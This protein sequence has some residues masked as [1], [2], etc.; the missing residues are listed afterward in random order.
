MRPEDGVNGLACSQEGEAVVHEE[1]PDRA[2]AERAPSGHETIVRKLRHR[3]GALLTALLSGGGCIAF[4]LALRGYRLRLSHVHLPHILDEWSEIAASVLLGAAVITV[5]I[6]LTL[7]LWCLW[8]AIRNVGDQDMANR[9][10]DLATRVVYM[11]TGGQLKGLRKGPAQLCGEVKALVSVA[12]EARTASFWELL[13][14][15]EQADLA[16]LAVETTFQAGSILCREG[17]RADHVIVI[18]SGRIKVCVE[19]PN[20]QQLVAIRHAGDIVGE[21]AA[22]QVTERSATITALETVTAHVVPTE[23]FA[24]FIQ[25]H[26]C[27]LTIIE[28][29][30]YG[31]LT[32]NASQCAIV[33]SHC[34][35]RAARSAG[36]WNGQNC[37]VVLID[38]A[39]FGASTRNDRDRT[40]IRA[41]L[42]Q[43]SQSLFENPDWQHD[44]HCEDRG[45]GILLVIPPHVPTS[46]IVDRILDNL[47]T[48]LR[49]HNSTAALATRIQMRVA[50]HVGPVISDAHG[51]NGRAIIHAARLL[52]APALKRHLAET[53]ADLGFITSPFVYDTIIQ[54][55]PGP[56]DPAVYQQLKC[57]VKKQAINAW[58]Y[59][60]QTSGEIQPPAARAGQIG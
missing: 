12:P 8:A 48:L 19:S 33:D 2:S 15:A 9:W 60:A 17:Q 23:D 1:S 56:V 25:R 41:A 58:M 39:N 5:L 50:L 24:A 43:I 45:D 42:Y 7:I 59:L 6:V 4:S 10:L 28:N 37:T 14:P 32:E 3:K 27:V 57:Q 21:R 30:I 29:Q 40:G 36:S 53:G 18:R 13:M 46:S 11:V 34:V 35:V 20:G 26:P 52:D 54:P 44:Y 22:L 47:V 51:V 49:R 31:R 55:N 16:A 38:I